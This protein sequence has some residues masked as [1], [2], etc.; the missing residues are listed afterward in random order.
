MPIRLAQPSKKGTVICP[1]HRWRNQGRRSPAGKDGLASRAALQREL[2]VPD[3]VPDVTSLERGQGGI[4]TGTLLPPKAVA[5]S[6]RGRGRPQ[7]QV[8][9]YPQLQRKPQEEVPP[10]QP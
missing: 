5:E 2:S 8:T 4:R 3:Q 6:V 1:F 9:I 10:A 7:P